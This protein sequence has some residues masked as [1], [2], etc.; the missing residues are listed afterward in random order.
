M[1]EPGGETG[2][3]D[4]DA[5]PEGPQVAETGWPDQAEGEGGPSQEDDLRCC[6]VCVGGVGGGGIIRAVNFKFCSLLM[7]S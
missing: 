3:G 5:S 6:T 2:S 4:S 1:K 7:F